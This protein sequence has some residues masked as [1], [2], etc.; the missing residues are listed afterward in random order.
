MTEEKKDEKK[1]ENQRKFGYGR[2]IQVV[3]GDSFIVVGGVVDPKVNPIAP[4]K[5]LA[6]S[7]IRA[8]RCIRGRTGVDEPFGYE[9]KEYLRDLIYGKQ[10]RFNINRASAGNRDY[11]DVYLEKGG[12]EPQDLCDT[13]IAAG[14]GKVNES[15]NPQADQFPERQARLKLQGEA[16]EKK[17]GM[18]QKSPLK[19]VRDI[20]WGA[21]FMVSS[22]RTREERNKAQDTEFNWAFD[23]K[24]KE[25][26]AVIIK[27]RDGSAYRCE[28]TGLYPKEPLKHKIMLITLSGCLC[29][30]VPPPLNVQKTMKD[31][32][33]R[34]VIV[35]N[36]PPFALEARQYAEERLLH[37]SVKIVIDGADK[38]G[39]VYATIVHPRGNIALRLLQKG[40]G[41]CVPWTASFSPLE[42][43]LIEA[44]QKA[45]TQ[46]L[47]LWT[48]PV[49]QV[50]GVPE[51]REW[52]ATITEV[53]SGD[54][55]RLD[56]ETMKR[57]SLASIKCPRLGRRGQEPGRFYFEAREFVR[58]KLFGKKVKVTF[59]Y[60]RFDNTFV[61]ISYTSKYQNK[62]VDLSEE[63]VAEG[64]ADMVIHQSVE[65][66]A[67]NYGK[68][69]ELERRAKK[70]KKNK[71]GENNPCMRVFDLTNRGPSGPPP[72]TT[73]ATSTDPKEK[74]PTGSEVK[75]RGDRLF[76]DLTR[77]VKEHK[78]VVEY[79]HSGGKMKIYLPN[80]GQY[81]Y[82][83]NFVISGVNVAYPKPRGGGPIDPIGQKALML[84]RQKLLQQDNVRIGKIDMKDR[85]ENFLGK[86]YV[87]K[88][89]W[90]K[91]LVSMGLGIVRFDNE[92]YLWEAQ[93]KAK[94]ARKGLWE[95]YVEPKPVEYGDRKKTADGETAA[96]RKPKSL[97]FDAEVTEIMDSTTFYVRRCG[98]ATFAK[99]QEALKVF[100][101]KI[102]E[103][104]PP[105]RSS[106]LVCAGKFSDEQWYRVRVGSA[107]RHGTY[108]CS[109][110]DY[111]NSEELSKDRLAPLPEEIQKLPSTC[112]SCVLAGVKAP[113]ASSAHANAAAHAFNQMAYGYELVAKIEDEDRNNKYHLTLTPKG[114]EISINSE[115]VKGGWAR[116]VPRPLPKL[117]GYCQKLKKHQE[118]A[119][120][121]KLNIWEYGDVSEED[122][123]EKG[124]K[125]ETGRPPSL[126]Q[127]RA[128]ALKKP[129]EPKK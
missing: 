26:D 109:F 90:G 42:S 119:I 91:L 20:E 30:K 36:A 76:K 44:G 55:F 77:S 128:A 87:G 38:L 11:A 98:D 60:N 116:V 59:A 37:Q 84:A 95:N 33:P 125:R 108:R 92:G 65:T 18:W 124:G 117:K 69:L 80:M 104:F 66:R 68:L 47:G 102:N 45:E 118:N 43:Q 15:K 64:F 67:K 78:V 122:S 32:N 39:N 110:I 100:E 57:H 74:A 120:R 48:L 8:P 83:L 5:E 13:I 94:E 9:S 126:A 50:L 58:E 105:P 127:K 97:V 82:L 34:Y 23:H 10:V 29:P 79:C 111:G 7:G 106:G 112:R 85:G 71:F 101:S 114:S 107:T 24:G 62:E 72:E 17:I 115:L 123:D 99:V 19:H 46:K 103:D 73:G 54:S 61:N 56:G 31:R 12:Q 96:P 51:K 70:Q 22:L 93:E 89:E 88:Q 6:I 40:L 63:L 4:T 16:E 1:V 49:V 113:G 53:S 28:V 81:G 129:V 35:E 27:I 3:S 75:A 52:E 86:L 21:S 14:W 121:N 41:K 2:V 25:L